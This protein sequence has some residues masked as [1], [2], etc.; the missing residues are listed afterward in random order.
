MQRDK[1]ARV[2]STLLQREPEWIVTPIVEH[3]AILVALGVGDPEAA[4]RAMT[5]HLE[6]GKGF[7]R[8][9]L[10]PR[11]DRES[12]VRLNCGPARRLRLHA[13]SRRSVV[14]S[15]SVL[16]ASTQAASSG[17]A[18]YSGSRCRP[19]VSTPESAPPGR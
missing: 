16:I 4:D 7:L 8:Q 6:R 5:A 1:L 2:V 3:D 10:P 17:T 14:R 12:R 9:S 11:P 13:M 19:C 15:A 18:V